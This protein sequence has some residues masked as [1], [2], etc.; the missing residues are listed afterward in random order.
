MGDWIIDCQCLFLL[1]L[2]YL[3]VATTNIGML[4]LA[5]DT[6]QSCTSLRTLS[7]PLQ[8]TQATQNYFI[9]FTFGGSSVR[10]INWLH[11]A[12]IRFTDVPPTV[13]ITTTTGELFNLILRL[14]P[15]RLSLIILEQSSDATTATVPFT[16]TVGV[17]TSTTDDDGAIPTP[18]ANTTD[19]DRQSETVIPV[20]TSTDHDISG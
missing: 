1:F 9:E 15:T 5:N 6:E 10:P 16:T 11:L 14:G 2:S 18:S 19:E 20:S 7:I 12:E 4:F 3:T 13:S 17:F 8:P